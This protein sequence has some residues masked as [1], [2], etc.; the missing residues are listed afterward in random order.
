MLGYTPGTLVVHIGWVGQQE[1][2][3]VQPSIFQ[4]KKPLQNKIFSYKL[5]LLY[6]TSIISY[7]YSKK[8]KKKKKKKTRTIFNNHFMNSHFHIQEQVQWV[9]SCDLARLGEQ[10]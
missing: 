8:K 5:F 4:K 3:S 2:K 10:V 7:Y 6:I 9:N 1:Y